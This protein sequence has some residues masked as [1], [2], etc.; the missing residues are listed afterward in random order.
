MVQDAQ[1]ASDDLVLEYG[2]RGDIDSFTM[3]G[4][5]DNRATQL[6]VCPKCNVT[7]HRQMI[8]LKNM[9]NRLEPRLKVADL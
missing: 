7:G 9:R 5:N 6:N 2:A 8:K 1:I 3:V 4:D